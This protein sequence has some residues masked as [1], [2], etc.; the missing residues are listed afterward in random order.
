MIQPKS[1]LIFSA[2]LLLVALLICTNAHGI[3]EKNI[4]RAEH[5]GVIFEAPHFGQLEEISQLRRKVH[6]DTASGV[7]AATQVFVRDLLVKNRSA[8]FAAPP[9]VK[10][11]LSFAYKRQSDHKKIDSLTNDPQL[12]SEFAQRAAQLLSDV[13]TKS[14]SVQDDELA[15]EKLDKRQVHERLEMIFDGLK[16]LIDNSRV[17]MY[18]D[19][20]E[21][22]VNGQRMESY[23]APIISWLHDNNYW[24]VLKCLNGLVGF[25]KKIEVTN[26]K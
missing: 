2:A 13:L 12:P 1:V 8:V 16:K 14:R 15:P 21:L 20:S 25:V 26:E 22:K 24:F 11:L 17:G 10:N 5:E 3:P 6:S 18:L 23:T 9:F 4:A 7:F 19:W